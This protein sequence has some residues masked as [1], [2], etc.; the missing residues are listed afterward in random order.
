MSIIL[1]L[2]NASVV[3]QTPT[4]RIAVSVG[5]KSVRICTWNGIDPDHAHADY[6]P[7]P[8]S[9][10]SVGDDVPLEVIQGGFTGGW[11]TYRR[12]GD[13]CLCLINGRVDEK[14]RQFIQ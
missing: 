11:H 6:H 12:V 3:G 7:A 4:R 2:K 10:V 13:E 8:G 9:V 14:P 1:D 5:S